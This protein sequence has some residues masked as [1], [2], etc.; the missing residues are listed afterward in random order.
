[1]NK[2][3]I[4]GLKSGLTKRE[5]ESQL[6]SFPLDD[7][8]VVR[9]NV[10]SRTVA[11]YC[12]LY[13]HY[14]RYCPGR[15]VLRPI[16]L[17]LAVLQITSAVVKADSVLSVGDPTIEKLNDVQYAS[18]STQTDC[19]EMEDTP[20]SGVQF[21]NSSTQ[22]DCE[23]MGDS[24]LTGGVLKGVEC[25]NSTTHTKLMLESTLSKNVVGTQG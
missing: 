5:I 18:S 9:C 11:N 15:R 7:G 2:I 23:K 6:G 4:T 16:E 12:R 14:A 24:L 13:Q 25:A 8:M 19:D 10:C 1:M 21:V 17:E 3:K 22:T 20:L